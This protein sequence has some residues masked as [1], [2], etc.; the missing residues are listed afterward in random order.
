MCGTESTSLQTRAAQTLNKSKFVLFA[1]RWHCEEGEVFDVRFV[2]FFPIILTSLW[3]KHDKNKT[4]TFLFEQFGMRDRHRFIHIIRRR[5]KR[6][7]K[8]IVNANWIHDNKFATQPTI[9]ETIVIPIVM[10]IVILYVLL[11][12]PH[13]QVN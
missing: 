10:M 4:L 2:Y 8:K 11:Y 13:I 6:T 12:A 7:N 9:N 3:C 5:K 1:C